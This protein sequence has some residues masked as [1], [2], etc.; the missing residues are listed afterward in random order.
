MLACRHR[1]Q[2]FF[3]LR[4]RPFF[5]YFISRHRIIYIVAAFVTE[6]VHHL[7]VVTLCQFELLDDDLLEFL[8]LL[9]A[10]TNHVCHGS[11]KLKVSTK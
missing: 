11:V 2:F 10:I 7:T 3:R 8:K 1:S 9:I 6:S 5:E 4:H